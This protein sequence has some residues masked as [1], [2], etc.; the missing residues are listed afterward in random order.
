[1]DAY[2]TEEQQVEALKDWLK[3]YGSTLMSLVAAVAIVIAGIAYW[4]HHQGVVRVQASEHYLAMLDGLAE[5]ED[6]TVKSKAEILLVN[7]A[8]SPYATLASFALAFKAV[9]Q[10]DFAHA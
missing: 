1:M 5:K 6:T 10:H 7:Y 3:K 8:A 2:V 4:K 9:E